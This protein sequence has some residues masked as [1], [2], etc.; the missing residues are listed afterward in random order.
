MITAPTPV[1]QTRSCSVNY[2]MN[3]STGVGGDGYNSGILP[4]KKYSQLQKPGYSQMI[5]FVDE[6]EYEVGDGCFGLYPTQLPVSPII[7][8]AWWN[9]PGSRHNKGATFSFLD[10]HAEYWKWLGTA[11]PS[12]NSPGG[13]WIARTANDLKD[14]IRIESDTL[15]YNPGP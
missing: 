12:F 7:G 13:P 8:S 3:G 10:G 11:I 15:P 5:V 6:S 1:P 14:L 9:P 4:L 2:A